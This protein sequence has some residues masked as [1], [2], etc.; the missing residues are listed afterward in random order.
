MFPSLISRKASTGPYLLPPPCCRRPSPC[1]S[2]PMALT[3]IIR[4]VGCLVTHD[5]AS[6]SP[7]I[8]PRNR[9]FSSKL[10]SLSSPFHALGQRTQTLFYR[11]LS[12]S[13]SFSS[14]S[15]SSSSASCTSK[16]PLT[17]G[18][19]RSPDGVPPQTGTKNS[20]IPQEETLSAAEWERRRALAKKRATV[21]AIT[22][23]AGGVDPVAVDAAKVVETVGRKS[24]FT[25]DP[26]AHEGGVRLCMC[27]PSIPC[28]H[29]SVVPPYL[30]MCMCCVFAPSCHFLTGP[31]VQYISSEHSLTREEY[32]QKISGAA[33]TKVVPLKLKLQVL[34]GTC[35]LCVSMSRNLRGLSSDDDCVV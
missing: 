11:E 1:L 25:E 7:A 33:P 3:P 8:L 18:L 32:E 26:C 4:R 10:L 21:Q 9:V 34:F 19:S 6:S 28:L 31:H 16:P 30:Y 35:L 5:A 23:S 27:L 15:S 20:R 22:R 14:S 29:V 2:A 24:T 17:S 13:R 12:L